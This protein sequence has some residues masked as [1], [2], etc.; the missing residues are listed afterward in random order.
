MT[1]SAADL[2]STQI[3]VRRVFLTPAPRHVDRS[4]GSVHEAGSL[5]HALNVHVRLYVD[6]AQIIQRELNPE[7]TVEQV[8]RHVRDS[9]TDV[10]DGK[11][12]VL[13]LLNRLGRPEPLSISI[14]LVRHELCE[15][16]NRDNGVDHVP[17][18]DGQ[19]FECLPHLRIRGSANPQRIQVAQ[20]PPEAWPPDRGGP[21]R[22]APRSRHA[23]DRRLSPVAGSI[24]AAA[25]RRRKAAKRGSLLG[26]VQAA[27]VPKQCRPWRLDCLRAPNPRG[28]AAPE[29]AK[30]PTRLRTSRFLHGSAETGGIC[31]ADHP[32]HIGRSQSVAGIT[33]RLFYRMA[34]NNVHAGSKGALFRL[35]I[36]PSGPDILLS[37]SS[38]AGLV[39]PGQDTALSLARITISLLTHES[40]MDTVTKSNVLYQL[41]L[42][43]RDAFF[44]AQV[45]LEDQETT[46]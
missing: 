19:D 46:K 32:L 8:D 7:V 18:L 45:A 44:D 23:P 34:S 17:W 15:G 24:R 10:S 5:E 31:T 16:A 36:F 39:D 12:R 40:N 21:C 35:G 20:M 27:A 37:G 4:T 29:A 26:A 38:V 11:Q 33:S 3:Q 14:E 9:W 1:P 43:T 28:R 30:N 6:V 22:R 13:D 42:E 41:C 2:P 25:I